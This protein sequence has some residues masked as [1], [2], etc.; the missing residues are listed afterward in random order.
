[1][2]I[3]KSRP[4]IKDKRM[5]KQEQHTVLPVPVYVVN[6]TMAMAK[7]FPSQNVIEKERVAHVMKFLYFGF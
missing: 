1:M 7:N 5:A 3:Y 6:M 4:N 2:C